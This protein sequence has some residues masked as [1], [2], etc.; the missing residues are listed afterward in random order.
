MAAKG[1]FL[2]HALDLPHYPTK[3]FCGAT[4]MNVALNDEVRTFLATQKVL[5]GERAAYSLFL[6]TRGN[7]AAAVADL[8]KQYKNTSQ[9]EA[10]AYLQTV[11]KTLDET[12]EKIDGKYVIYR[13]LFLTNVANEADA[14][15]IK[16]AFNKYNCKLTM[17]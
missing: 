12:Y 14:K 4:P 16:V 10:A 15:A 1:A 3:T 2:N 6:E 8:I 17:I 13:P 5:P 11:K 7:D 9:A